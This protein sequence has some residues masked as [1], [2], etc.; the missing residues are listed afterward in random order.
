MCVGVSLTPRRRAW[1][2]VAAGGAYDVSWMQQ[3]PSVKGV[4]SLPFPGQVRARHAC[5]QRWWLQQRGEGEGHVGGS[6]VHACMQRS[7]ARQ[8][9]RAPPLRHESQRCAA[10][11]RHA[12]T[13]GA[14]Q[15]AAPTR[16]STGG[17]VRPGRHPLW[18]RVALGP[19]AHHLVHSRLHRQGAA[20]AAGHAAR[21]G[22][23]LPGQEL[24]VRLWGR[25]AAARGARVRSTHTHRQAT[26]CDTR[27]AACTTLPG[28]KRLFSTL[29]VNTRRA[30]LHTPSTHAPHTRRAHTPRDNTQVCDGAI[31]HP[32]PLWQRGVLHNLCLQQHEG[33]GAWAARVPR[34]CWR[35]CRW[36]LS[37]VRC[38]R[39]TAGVGRRRSAARRRRRGGRGAR[40][41]GGGAG[42]RAAVC[43]H[44]G[45]KHGRGR[46]SGAVR[47]ASRACGASVPAPRG[48]RGERALLCGACLR[49]SFG[50]A[51]ALASLASPGPFRVPPS[52]GLL[53]P[54]ATRQPAVRP[55]PSTPTYHTPSPPPHHHHHT[56]TH[57]HRARAATRSARCAPCSARP[58]WRRASP[59]R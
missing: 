48:Q 33:D 21:A 59:R 6:V 14:P 44:H 16:H 17:R 4:L 29:R 26:L 31:L 12:H 43:E 51:H 7:R 3:V 13:R 5:C 18:P 28:A 38:R 9:G 41:G 40:R 58:R 42:R 22:A 15:R 49:C 45:H 56:H 50:L 52:A 8:R 2:A 10:Q 23:Q 25:A 30:T 32:V 20:A 1:C 55:C 34:H 46:C 47:G 19:P 57:T 37:C 36:R 54:L 27:L 35:R 11:P 53:P 39:H 24:Q